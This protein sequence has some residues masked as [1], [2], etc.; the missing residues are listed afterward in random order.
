MK[1]RKFLV[2]F[3]AHFFMRCGDQLLGCHYQNFGWRNQNICPS[4]NQAFGSSNQAPEILT[5]VFREGT[6]L[7]TTC[8]RRFLN[9]ADAS[10]NGRK[11]W[12]FGWSFS[13]APPAGKPASPLCVLPNSPHPRV[14]CWVKLL[15][16]CATV[17]SPK[18]EAVKHRRT[19]FLFAQIKILRKHLVHFFQWNQ[20]R[21]HFLNLYRRMSFR[22][23]PKF[24]SCRDFLVIEDTLWIKF[25]M[26][27]VRPIYENSEQ[28]R[29]DFFFEGVPV[30]PT[31]PF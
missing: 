8:W 21:W 23:D 10:S 5:W 19:S 24:S 29:F 30:D 15:A 1:R 22:D 9:N 17:L 27:T 20:R 18:Q 25:L 28:P 4:I 16:K 7:G 2:R 14:S 26:W 6:D 31:A 3:Q 11:F 13:H 12:G